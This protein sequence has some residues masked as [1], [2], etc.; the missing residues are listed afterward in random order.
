MASP[1]EQFEVV[2]LQPL[3]AGGYDL[4]FTNS[5]LWMAIAIGVIVLFLAKTCVA[6]PAVRRRKVRFPVS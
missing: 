5:S 6:Q 3:E 4:S 2:Q 1:M